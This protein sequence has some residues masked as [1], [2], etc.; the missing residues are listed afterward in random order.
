MPELAGIVGP[1]HFSVD[2]LVPP[3]ESGFTAQE[4]LCF[5]NKLVSVGLLF[6]CS[7]SSPAP[8][9]GQS[10]ANGLGEKLCWPRGRG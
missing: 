1:G 9:A 5:E 7:Y 6:P 4:G 2:S 8:L 10:Q 3:P